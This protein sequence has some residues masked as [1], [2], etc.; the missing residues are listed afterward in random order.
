MESWDVAWQQEVDRI[1]GPATGQES[2]V[3]VPHDEPA[4]QQIAVKA[5]P[6]RKAMKNSKKKVKAKSGKQKG[7]KSQAKQGLKKRPASNSASKGHVSPAQNAQEALDKELGGPSSL[8][9][10]AHVPLCRA[11]KIITTTGACF[12]GFCADHWMAKLDPVLKQFWL[13]TSW[14]CEKDKTAQRF[15]RGNLAAVQKFGD[16]ELNEFQSAPRVDSISG[17]FPC[18]PHSIDPQGILIQYCLRRR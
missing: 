3:V 5:P 12:A 10:S 13:T 1:G 9:N 4:A 7:A 6:L 2:P 11:P 16:I 14:W 18:Q 15:L 8:T 17:G